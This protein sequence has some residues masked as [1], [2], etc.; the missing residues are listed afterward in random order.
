MSSRVEIG[1]GAVVVVA[2]ATNT[3]LHGD[4]AAQVIYLAVVLGA[5]VA[6]CV[7]A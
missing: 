2:V 5:S 6:A 3:A 4:V 1:V 7:G